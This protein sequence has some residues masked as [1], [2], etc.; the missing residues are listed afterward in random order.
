MKLLLDTHCWLWQLLEPV[1]LNASASA[2]LIDP[3]HEI[4]FSAASA[5]E[6]VVKFGLGKLSIPQPPMEYIPDRMAAMGHRPLPIT[7]THALKLHGLPT[8][9]KDPF[10]RILV[11]QALVENM[12]LMTADPMLRKYPAPL[13]WAG[14]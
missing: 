12:Q 14:T 5:W 4:Y 11:A 13:I 9:H 1:K 6:I 7:Q 8:V 2:L 3:T 10:D